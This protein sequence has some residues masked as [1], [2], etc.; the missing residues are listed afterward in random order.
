[1]RSLIA[2]A[3]LLFAADVNEE[4]VAVVSVRPSS[5]LQVVSGALSRDE[6][7]W[8]SPTWPRCYFSI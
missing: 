4:R 8:P 3:L 5:Q 1:M 2:L 6:G 7:K